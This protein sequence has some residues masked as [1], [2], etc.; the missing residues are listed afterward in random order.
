MRTGPAPDRLPE[1]SEVSAPPKSW[2]ASSELFRSWPRRAGY[3]PPFRGDRPGSLANRARP[4]AGSSRSVFAPKKSE[5]L[6]RAD[7]QE[8]VTRHRRALASRPSAELSANGSFELRVRNAGRGRRAG[9][10]SSPPSSGV[11]G[12]RRRR[13]RGS[14]KKRNERFPGEIETPRPSQALENG[15]RRLRRGDGRRHPR[16]RRGRR[17]SR[18]HVFSR[19]THQRS[20]SPRPRKRRGGSPSAPPGVPSFGSRAESVPARPLRSRP[21]DERGGPRG[22]LPRPHAPAPVGR[23][24]AAADGDKGGLPG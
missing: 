10:P 4:S 3:R 9:A 18:K 1:P 19:P 16:L 14:N 2:P 5:E 6:A 8:A 15:A 17:A 11:G 13:R 20:R 22:S 21:R 7:R 24:L 23:P 12:A